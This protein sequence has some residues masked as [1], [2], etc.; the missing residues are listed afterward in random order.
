MNR[1]TL[2]IGATILFFA[3]PAAAKSKGR[4]IAALE[5]VYK[6]VSSRGKG[7]ELKTPHWDGMMFIQNGRFS[8]IYS[9][10]L[11]PVNKKLSQRELFHANAG[12]LKLENKKILMNIEMA[13]YRPLEG[14]AFS[15]AFSFS[16]DGQTLTLVDAKG[17]KEFKEVWKRVRPATQ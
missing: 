15:D 3:L 7:F 10:K 2:L 16:K 6:L 9:R 13:S 8:R 4:S 1:S 11:A 5:G 17:G 12:T 14:Q